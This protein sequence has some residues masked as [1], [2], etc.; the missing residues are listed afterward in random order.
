MPN[1]MIRESCRT[2]ETLDRLSDGAERLFWRLTTVADDYGRFEADPRVLLAHCFPL[3]VGLL[4]VSAV[5]RLF[6][7]LVICGLVTTY[8]GGGKRLGFFTTWD[9]HQRIRAQHSKYPPPSSDNI[10]QQTTADVPVVVVEVTE[11]T[12]GE[13]RELLAAAGD[14]FDEFWQAYPRKQDK[15]EAQ[16][17][18]RKLRPDPG[19]RAVILSAVAAQ[20]G[21]AD[22]TREGGRFIPYP[23]TWLNKGRW[24]D[25]VAPAQIM[26]PVN[27]AAA[28][29][30]IERH[31]GQA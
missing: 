14:G 21:G 3:K 23:A 17:A 31:G 16:A 2:S 13:S 24:T 6:R 20:R 8:D 28:R 9:K 29:R 11:E 22:W 10:C 4:K 15:T 30:F 5:G 19:L 25:E 18:W 27:E 1:R 12:E 7:E 26:S